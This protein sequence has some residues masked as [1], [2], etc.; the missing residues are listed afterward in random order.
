[1]K[2]VF[3]WGS[4]YFSNFV[5]EEIDKMGSEILGIVDNDIKKQHTIWKEN[6]MIYP[7]EV[8]KKDSFDYVVISVQKYEPIVDQCCDMGLDEAKLIVYWKD[9]AVKEVFPNRTYRIHDLVEE[10]MKYQIRL[11]NA[12]YELGI[13]QEPIIK[14]AESLLKDIIK[15]RCSLSRFGDGEFELMR[16]RP[17]PWFQEVDSQLALRLQEVMDSKEKRHILA[18]ANN[19]GSLE[20]YTEDAADGIRKYMAGNTRQEIME[21][22]DL[23]RVY[24]D[25]YVT[26]PYIIYK[27][28][29]K[30][31]EI[32]KLFQAVWKN[33]DVILVEGTYAKTGIENDLLITAKSVRRIICPACNAWNKYD[34][35]LSSVKEVAKKEDLV[36]VSLGPTATVLAYDLHKEGLQT[37]DIGQ[38]DNEYDWYCRKAKERIDIK[39]KMVAEVKTVCMEKMDCNGIYNSQI[40]VRLDG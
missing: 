16:K 38:L 19:F 21:L 3:I 29:S 5:Y 15:E 35:I 23:E 20:C 37:I 34:C 8:L 36:C 33:R 10:K 30:A 2:K 6:I 28:K 12:P 1:M 18:I 26:R 39:G 17:R 24:Y 9:D 22:I 7:P 40:I 4:G 27:D 32:F 11:E 13:M 14:S 25:A 31:G